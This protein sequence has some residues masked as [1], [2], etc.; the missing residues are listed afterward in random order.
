[1]QGSVGL[2]PCSATGTHVRVEAVR[3][4][5]WCTCVPVAATSSMLIAASHHTCMAASSRDS[6]M[7]RHRIVNSH[8]IYDKV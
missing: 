4:E 1:M 7:I 6:Q 3:A 2:Q 5:V 8:F